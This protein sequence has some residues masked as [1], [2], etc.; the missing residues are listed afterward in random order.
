MLR[1]KTQAF[2]HRL[3]QDWKPA[4]HM[5][6][7]R[8][9]N[10]PVEVLQEIA[11]HLDTAELCSIRL[12]CKRIYES[13]RRQFACAF[14]QTL[15]TDLSITRLERLRAISND[16]ELAP[17][18]HTLVVR[19]CPEN[20]LG[21]GLPWSRHSLGYLLP[22]QGVQ[23]WTDVLRRLVN[24]TSFHLIR[25]GWSDKDEGLDHLA[26]TDA[27]TVILNAIIAARI[28]V[29]EFLV[30]FKPANSAGA[31]EL[32]V[33]RINVADLQESRFIAAWASLQA[34]QLNFTMNPT[35]ITDWVDPLV[36]R[37]TRLRKLT[38]Q[39]D[40]GFEAEAIIERL[41]SI[42]TPSQL[43]ELTLRSAAEINGARL[44]DL[45]CRYRDSL[46]VLDME[47][48]LLSGP[49]WKSIFRTIGEFPLLESFSFGFLKEDI[50]YV[51]FPI[52][53]ENPVTDEATKLTLRS[54]MRRGQPINTSI[55]CRGPSAKVIVQ[56]LAESMEVVSF[57]RPNPG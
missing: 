40:L 9:H 26:P 43:Q 37:A 7:S 22:E 11:S 20:V 55:S 2:L 6:S 23:Q 16:P 29:R 4:S 49:G 54:R 18:V 15:H 3:K 42:D 48:I 19:A 8:F 12:S 56:K 24:C 27:I 35:I 51:H 39:F 14:F 45:L 31:N 52:A 38:I 21:E 50:Y 44:S 17:H 33:R 1:R 10:L 36:R 25:D 46:R 47:S 34:L 13:T 28:P 53:S 57:L 30:D 5:P 41:S 32:D